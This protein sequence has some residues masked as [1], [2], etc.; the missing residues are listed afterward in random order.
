MISKRIRCAG[1]GHEGVR[2]ING[3]G[4][5]ESSTCVFTDQGHDPYSGKL[6]FCCPQCGMLV[7]VDPAE[8]LENDVMNGQPSPVEAEA[9]RLTGTEG[10][11]PVWS[12]MYAAF[13]LFILVT[14]VFC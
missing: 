9:A 10:L 13:A 14:R 8:A 3:S 5:V 11:L 7:A 1:C 4:P 2:E 12:G 6:Y